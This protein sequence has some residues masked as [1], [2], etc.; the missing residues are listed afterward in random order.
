M[1]NNPFSLMQNKL[2]RPIRINRPTRSSRL[3]RFHSNLEPLILQSVC[4]PLNVESC[5]RMKILLSFWLS[6][7]Y[8]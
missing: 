5:W 1:L 7:N 2:C 3:T 8:T 4:S 6:N